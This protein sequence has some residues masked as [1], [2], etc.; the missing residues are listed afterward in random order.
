MW[1]PNES[2]RK[3]KVSFVASWIRFEAVRENLEGEA[4]KKNPNHKVFMLKKIMNCKN[5]IPG[6]D[7]PVADVFMSDYLD[8]V[9][10]V[11]VEEKNVPFVLKKNQHFR[12]FR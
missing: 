10:S 11:Q 3:N 2:F 5:F 4:K 1:S 7:G 8:W 12:N 6:I 9:L